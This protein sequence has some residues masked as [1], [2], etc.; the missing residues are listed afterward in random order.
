MQGNWSEARLV[1][2]VAGLIFE[3]VFGQT[4]EYVIA[5]NVSSMYDM[6]GHEKADLALT[7]WP[8]RYWGTMR[9]AALNTPCRKSSTKRCVS[10]VGNQGYQ[11]RSGWFVTANPT[12]VKGDLVGWS[13]I[14]SLLSRAGK[15]T[16]EFTKNL[17]KAH[18]LNVTNMCDTHNSTER[19]G[20]FFNWLLIDSN[21]NPHQVVPA[22][23]TPTSLEL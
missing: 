8:A 1:P 16:S 2:H 10:I 11:G 23:L 14:T 18:E 15:L 12:D 22:I 5:D 17:T 19:D 4:V 9:S 6:L 13:T 21:P 20:G 7:L 3:R